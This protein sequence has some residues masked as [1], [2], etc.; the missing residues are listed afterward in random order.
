MARLINHPFHLR[1]VGAGGTPAV[2]QSESPLFSRGSTAGST[3]TFD[4]AKPS[5]S[6]YP[7]LRLQTTSS[8]SA[9]GK[10][11]GFGGVVGREYRARIR[12]YLTEYHGTNGVQLMHFMRATGPTMICNI[13]LANDGA[14][15]LRDENNAQI[16]A[17][18]APLALNEWHTV[19]L[20]V[21]VSAVANQ[22]TLRARLDGVEFASAVGTADANTASPVNV[23]TGL[24][25][26]ITWANGIWIC[27]FALNDDQGASETGWPGHDRL[28]GQLLPVADVALGNWTDGIGGTGALWEAL[29]NLPPAGVAVGSETAASQIKNANAAVPSSYD[30]QLQAYEDVGLV[31]ADTIVL[32]QAFAHVANT[33]ASNNAGTLAVVSGGPTADAGAAVI[34]GLSSTFTASPNRWRAPRG[35]VLIGDVADKSTQPVVRI[36]KDTATTDGEHVDSLGLYFEY[37]EAEDT[38]GPTVAI[39]TPTANQTVMQ[40]TVLDLAATASDPAGVEGVQ[41]K[42]DGANHGAQDTV[43]P[44]ET[45]LDTTALALGEHTIAAEATDLLS[46]V[47]TASL[48]ITVKKRKVGGG[49]GGGGPGGTPKTGV[50][51]T[52]DKPAEGVVENDQALLI[53]ASDT[54]PS[55]ITAGWTRIAARDLGGNNV[56]LLAYRRTISAADVAA[57]NLGTIT[58]PV[59]AK[60]VAS[61]GTIVAADPDQVVGR[62]ITSAEIAADTAFAN[63]IDPE[64]VEDIVMAWAVNAAPGFS[65]V[66]PT[67]TL[68]IADATDPTEGIS[69]LIVDLGVP[70]S[71]STTKTATSTAI[72]NVAMLALTLREPASPPPAVDTTDPEVAIT[73]PADAAQVEG[74]VEVTATATDASGIAQVVFRLDG[75]IFG[76]G[77]AAPFAA[78]FDADSVAAGQHTVEVTATDTYGNDSVDTI[79]VT[80]LSEGGLSER[81]RR[82]KSGRPFRVLRR[83]RR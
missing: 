74:V 71:E 12:V 46:N 34:F 22:G 64:F 78:S 6:G 50:Q 9:I 3:Y 60:G 82:R 65:F 72:G 11:D 23:R 38:T 42:V 56:K 7:S 1:L 24:C 83:G 19:E 53:F 4:A 63:T 37:V 26:S 32:V 76:V 52:I 2:E 28:T 8:T 27:D 75:T 29:N 33:D 35:N 68:V 15:T 48:T 55:T 5:P 79:T 43:A 51:W 66:E 40:G 16:G 80:K 61:V 81:L 20:A 44:Y 67:D 57:A 39:T 47:S 73:A 13:T 62:I 49:A 70:T 17:A 36:T 59:N 69:L 31:D 45:T 58:F 77:A 21:N 41:W 25:S 14:L 18:T 54:L 30:A 10:W